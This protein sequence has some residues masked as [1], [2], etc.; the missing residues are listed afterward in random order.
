MEQRTQGSTLTRTAALQQI[1]QPLGINSINAASRVLT[2]T[3][4]RVLAAMRN[5]YGRQ[6]DVRRAFANRHART[7]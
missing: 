7:N 1:V 2:E 4:P 6:G 5:L 3:D